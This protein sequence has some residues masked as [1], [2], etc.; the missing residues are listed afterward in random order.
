M[1]NRYAIILHPEAEREVAEFYDYVAD[2]AGPTV[3][4]TYVTKL[5]AFLNGLADFSER[6][7][8]RESEVPGI[9]II[10][11]RRSVSIAF[12]VRSSEVIILGLFFSGRLVSDDILRNRL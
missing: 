9:R 10:G 6:G 7:T 3:A 4:W 5:R 1:G 12:V 11:Y 2:R 8:V